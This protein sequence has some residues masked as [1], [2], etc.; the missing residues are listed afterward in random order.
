MR[1]DRRHQ[2]NIAI[3]SWTVA[4]IEWY[5]FFVYGTAAA[6]VFPAAFF[7]SNAPLVG[8]LLSFATFGVGFI[9]LTMNR[10]TWAGRRSLCNAVLRSQGLQ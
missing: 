8:T 9:C 7:P 2:P 10:N 4:R 3:S 5:D 6:L 1:S